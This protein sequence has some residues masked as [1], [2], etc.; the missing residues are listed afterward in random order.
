MCLNIPF[1]HPVHL[2]NPV[3]F[4]RPSKKRTGN[5]G[6]VRVAGSLSPFLPGRGNFWGKGSASFYVLAESVELIL[7]SQ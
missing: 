7:S 1:F 4:L 2:V 5:P 6:D 3:Y